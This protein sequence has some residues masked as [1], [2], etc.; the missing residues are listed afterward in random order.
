MLWC[1]YQI[2]FNWDIHYLVPLLVHVPC[3]LFLFL[4]RLFQHKQTTTYHTYILD[5]KNSFGHIENVLRVQEWINNLDLEH[6]LPDYIEEENGDG[7]IDSP[8]SDNKILDNT[9]SANKLLVEAVVKP[10][11]LK[12][13]TPFKNSTTPSEEKTGHFYQIYQKILWRILQR[14][15]VPMKK[16]KH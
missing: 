16:E 15:P 8:V 3:I 10:K 6:N 2:S 12:Q 4:D 5:A 9:E 1:I 13:L 14:S 7:A 11:T